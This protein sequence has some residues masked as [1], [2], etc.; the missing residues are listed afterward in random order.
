MNQPDRIEITPGVV[1][2]QDQQILHI[3]TV[4]D[5]VTLGRVTEPFDT[6][7][8]SVARLKEILG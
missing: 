7:V 3:D 4:A 1:I 6:E 5:K 8:V 2:T